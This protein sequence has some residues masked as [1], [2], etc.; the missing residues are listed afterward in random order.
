MEQVK[1]RVETTKVVQEELTNLF[2][3]TPRTIRKAL[4]E[5]NEEGICP[6][7]RKAA[8]EKGGYVVVEVPEVNTWFDHEGT[9]HQRFANG[10][11]LSIKKGTDVGVASRKGKEIGRYTLTFVNIGEVQEELHLM[12][13]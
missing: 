8:I 11:E 10:I 7:I 2:K 4:L 9:M 12:K 1:R 6:R 3:V 5:W 13:F